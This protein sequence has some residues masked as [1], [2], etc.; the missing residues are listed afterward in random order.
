MTPEARKRLEE[1]LI[2]R[3]END[4]MGEFSKSATRMFWLGAEAAWEMREAEIA[5]LKSELLATS[6]ANK[7]Y[8][9][10]ISSRI[11]EAVKV[12]RERCLRLAEEYTGFEYLI[13]R[14]K[15]PEAE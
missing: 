15:N 2:R 5:K 1:A 7:G 8:A 11:A 14:I 12:E 9:H 13:E 6:V 3:A 10:A 4:P